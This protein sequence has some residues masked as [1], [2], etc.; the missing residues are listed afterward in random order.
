MSRFFVSTGQIGNGNIHI[1]GSDVKHITKVLRLR[2]GDKLTAVDG[3]GTEYEAQITESNVTEIICQIVAQKEVNREAPLKVTLVQGLPKGDK[4]ELI[5]QKCTEIGVAEIIPVATER[6]VVQLDAA[7][8]VKRRERWQRVAEE[9]AK[10]AGRTVVP[11]VK[12]VTT[13]ADVMAGISAEA[14]AIM[15]WEAETSLGLKEILSQYASKQEVYIF[16][17]PEGGFAQAEVEL[18]RRHGL[19][20]VTMGPRIMRTET[21]GMVALTMVLY[22]LGDLGGVSQ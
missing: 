9:A 4:M 7:K 14:L 11:V 2:T 19:H 8:A 1:T 15:P 22:Q 16:I 6:A 13:L 10:Q 18:A 17:G 20:I 3:Q 12:D 5:I 21:A